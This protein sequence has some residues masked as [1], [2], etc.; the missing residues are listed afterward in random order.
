MS[1]S[2]AKAKGAREDAKAL[3][4]AKKS[5]DVKGGWFEERGLRLAIFAD[6]LPHIAIQYE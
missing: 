6:S 3:I 5:K 1:K 2:T 4:V